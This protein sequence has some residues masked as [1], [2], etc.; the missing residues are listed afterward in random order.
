MW[1]LFTQKQKD[2][3]NK[4]AELNDFVDTYNSSQER[5]AKISRKSRPDVTKT[6]A[7]N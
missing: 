7:E 5:V 3:T 1:K 2:Y 6:N 4:L